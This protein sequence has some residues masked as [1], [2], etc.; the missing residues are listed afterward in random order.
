MQAIRLKMRFERWFISSEWDITDIELLIHKSIHDPFQIIAVAIGH[1]VS[2][3]L[4]ILGAR[5][6][7]NREAG[8]KTRAGTNRGERTKLIHNSYFKKGSGDCLV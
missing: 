7:G 1:F 3:A 8:A 4:N 5:P 6:E 2:V